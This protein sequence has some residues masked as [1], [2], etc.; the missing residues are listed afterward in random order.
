[1]F[2]DDLD[3]ATSA[4]SLSSSR[5]F[6]VV[7]AALAGSEKGLETICGKHTY[8]V[9]VHAAGAN[10]VELILGLLLVQIL[11]RTYVTIDYSIAGARSSICTFFLT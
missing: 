7:S 1:M 5:L 9:S 10:C 4:A 11:C 3:K 8:N 2:G 6:I